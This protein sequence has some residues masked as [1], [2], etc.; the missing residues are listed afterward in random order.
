VGTGSLA[1]ELDLLNTDSFVFLFLVSYLFGSVDSYAVAKQYPAFAVIEHLLSRTRKGGV[2]RTLAAFSVC[3]I[4]LGK[5]VFSLLVAKSLIGTGMSYA[6]ASLA[7]FLG[8]NWPIDRRS[9]D[10]LSVL[11][12]L[13]TLLLFSWQGTAILVIIWG[14]VRLVSSVEE[15]AIVVAALFAPPILWYSR[16][17]DLYVLFGFAILVIIVYQ[18]LPAIDISY[19]KQRDPGLA[20]GG[21][22]KGSAKQVHFRRIFAVLLLLILG[23]VVFFNRYVYRGFGLHSELFRHGNRQLKYI[24]IT[25][26]DGPDPK[27]TPK[28]LDILKEENVRATFFVVGAHVVKYPEVARR[29][30][31][32]GHEIGNHT[33]SHRNLYR[34]SKE[35]IIEEIEKAHEAIMLVIGEETHLLRPPRGMYDSNV[36]EISHSRRY[37]IVLWSLSSQDWAE[38]S[39]GTVRRS[40]L[41][42]IQNGDILLFHDSGNI[43]SYEGGDRHNTV[44]ALPV[45]VRELK[46]MGYQFVTITEMMII[47]G[48]TEEE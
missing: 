36:V 6:V 42:N 38:V 47:S 24:A 19:Q 34:L 27:Y 18:H 32:E 16:E 3:I 5:G 40:I 45:I 15:V 9:K 10:N 1:E 20:N 8:C 22:H 14:L 17:K 23:L 31:E 4:E 7:C 33:Y 30:V 48:L 12:V 37:T 26:D 35:H 2:S 41:N 29:I 44:V 39:A 46:D 13:P 11:A 21:K 43:V 25:F 28:I